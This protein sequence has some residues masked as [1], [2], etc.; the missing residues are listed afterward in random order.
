[1]GCSGQ[2]GVPH[3]GCPHRSPQSHTDF[4][5]IGLKDVLDL[6]IYETEGLKK[7]LNC[8][9]AEFKPNHKTVI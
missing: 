3:A 6:A 9:T 1:M 2:T 5:H 8:I 4:L 7:V